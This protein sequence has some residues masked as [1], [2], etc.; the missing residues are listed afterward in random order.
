MTGEMNY[1]LTD[2]Q[3]T[4]LYDL[5]AGSAVKQIAYQRVISR[6]TIWQHLKDAR[7]RLGAQTRDQ[8]IAI[9]VTHFGMSSED[10]K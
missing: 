1:A 4:I 7:E 8:T 10:R 3:K 2:T 9:F 5:A 6:R